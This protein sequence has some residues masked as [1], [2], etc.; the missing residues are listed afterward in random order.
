[1]WAD[2]GGAT[3]EGLAENEKSKSDSTQRGGDFCG[4]LPGPQVLHGSRRL[5]RAVAL[6]VGCQI[7]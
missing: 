4:C 5:S 7:S 3:Q 2:C 1:M 6:P